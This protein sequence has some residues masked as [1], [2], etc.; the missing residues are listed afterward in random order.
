MGSNK[1]QVNKT[2]KRTEKIILKE[3]SKVAVQLRKGNL[4]CKYY[5]QSSTYSREFR[6]FN[7][8]K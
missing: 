7:C 5:F 1:L 6:Q 4:T 3:N 8:E 2:N